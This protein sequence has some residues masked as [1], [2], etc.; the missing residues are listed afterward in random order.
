MKKSISLPI[1]LL[2]IIVTSAAQQSGVGPGLDWRTYTVKDEEFSASLPASPAM[3]TSEGLRKDGKRRLERLLK[4]SSSGVDYY[5]EIFENPEPGQS[6]EQFIAEQGLSTEYDRG[7][8]RKLTVDG[9]AG[10]EYS[11]S[12][13]KFPARVQIFATE[14]H[15]SRFVVRGPNAGQ[16]SVV[17]PFFPQ[18]NWGK[19]WRA[20]KFLMGPDLVHLYSLK[21]AKEYLQEEKLIQKHAC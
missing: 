7:S 8:E 20:R 4:T 13:K 6:L 12:N 3:M 18:S 9:F 16:P 19:S 10:I 17:A 14:K 15:L 21:L 5:I 1:C 11:S 2:V